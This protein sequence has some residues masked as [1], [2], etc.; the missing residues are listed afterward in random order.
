[1]K[2]DPKLVHNLHKKGGTVLET[3]R[4]GFDL[5]KIVDGIQRHGFNQRK[6]LAPTIADDATCFLFIFEIPT[7]LTAGGRNDSGIG[8]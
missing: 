8:T 1:V 2:L 5:E 4:G 3:S 7:N 6:R